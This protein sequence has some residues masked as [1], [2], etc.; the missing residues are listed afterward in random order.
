MSPEGKSFF[1]HRRLWQGFSGFSGDKVRQWRSAL[2]LWSGLPFH[3]TP[4]DTA[5]R[6]GTGNVR[7]FPPTFTCAFFFF[8]H[9]RMSHLQSQ[10][11]SL[12]IEGTLGMVF[13]CSPLHVIPHCQVIYRG[14]ASKGEKASFTE[15]IWLLCETESTSLSVFCLLSNLYH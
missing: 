10:S 2:P 12:H 11:C 13:L 3:L 8:L 5:L 6:G 4:D 7:L 15:V 14:L 9:D 1:E